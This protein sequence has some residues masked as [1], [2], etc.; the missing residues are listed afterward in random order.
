MAAV[1][2]VAPMVRVLRQLL[3]DFKSLDSAS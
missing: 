2:D 3:S 1:N